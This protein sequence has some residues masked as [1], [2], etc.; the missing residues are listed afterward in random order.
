LCRQ[1]LH[2]LF[3]ILGSVR[4]QDLPPNAVSDLSVHQNQA[5]VD[6]PRDC[7]AAGVDDRP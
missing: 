5:R 1:R 4:T 6:G 7:T 2:N 3:T